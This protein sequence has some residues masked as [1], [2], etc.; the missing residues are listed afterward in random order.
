MKLNKQLSDCVLEIE[1]H[2]IKLQLLN[3]Q[4]KIA[5]DSLEAA[6]AKQQ[7][8]K[9]KVFKVYKNLN[10]HYVGSASTV[11][12]TILQKLNRFRKLFRM[13]SDL[14]YDHYTN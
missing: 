1:E 8:V 14:N 2:T 9:S 10:A 13:L 3:K 12:F 6:Q 5:K 7:E 4:L 11:D